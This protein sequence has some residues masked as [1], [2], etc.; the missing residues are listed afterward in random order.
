MDNTMAPNTAEADVNISRSEEP[1]GDLFARHTVLADWVLKN[2]GFF[3]PD[4]E[5][6]YSPSIGYHVVV[7]EDKAVNSRTR[8]ASCPM[9]CTLS[10]LNALNIEPFSDHGTKFPRAFL[11][12]N[13]A[14][15]EML[16]AFFLMEQYVL[17]GKSW[18]APYVRTLPSVE[19]VNALQFDTEDD[20]LWIKGTNLETGYRELMMKWKAN[21]QKGVKDLKAHGWDRCGS[22]TWELYRWAASMFGSRGFSSV[23]LS[24]TIPSEQA[25][26]AA[27]QGGR[28]DPVVREVFDERFAVLL[29][30]LDILNHKSRAKIEWQPRT[31][32]VG[33]QVLENYH[34]GEQIY[35]NYG[36]KDNES[37]LL[38]YGFV[39]EDRSAQHVA[40]ALRVPP[41]TLLDAVKTWPMDP[42]ANTE[43]KLYIL[44]TGHH[45]NATATCLESSL[46]DYSLLDT[47]S[48]LTA[49]ERETSAMVTLRKTLMSIG[50]RKPHRF[51]D[52][53][54][55]LA[56]L[57]QLMVHCEKARA[58]LT[59]TRPT[60]EPKSMKQVN[61][62]TLR[63]QQIS[64]Y[65]D[66]ILLCRIVLALACSSDIEDA[67]IIDFATTVSSQDNSDRDSS[68]RVTALLKQHD[69]ITRSGEL[70]SLPN[71]FDM[72]LNGIRDSATKLIDEVSKQ[73]KSDDRLSVYPQALNQ[74]RISV[75]LSAAY[76]AYTRGAKLTQR[77]TD[78]LEQAVAWYPPD[79]ENWAYVPTASPWPPGEEPPVA[80]Q[81]LLKVAKDYVQDRTEASEADKINGMPESSGDETL[82][83]DTVTQ[84]L[85]P[86]SLCWAF[87][88]MS[89]ETLQVPIEVAKHSHKLYEAPHEVERDPMD[90]LLYISSQ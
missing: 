54:N 26:F 71:L 25:Q 78:W 17:G 5:I 6:A 16:Q 41:G 82:A 88:V 35:N 64:H 38:S 65:D 66:A 12:K 40:L 1:D 67:N 55:L 59:S 13:T 22:Y 83:I 24:D 45:K 60:S 53:R 56:V 61:A 49:N 21:Y 32:Y 62:S 51:D 80:L 14:N 50:L 86:E 10:V 8:I 72:L 89:E 44:N 68:R 18:W 75:F 27:T 15:R 30:L 37:L 74:C 19:D 85:K 90:V 63:T 87:N 34:S 2:G 46:F 42:R 57:A 36:P 76:H 20:E 58:R 31:S 52:F 73:L 4:I 39:T 11:K 84:W 47:I 29:P 48:V 33:L 81:M 3:H 70:F 77:L 7:V 9:T 79:D 43:N 28:V 69:R 23:V